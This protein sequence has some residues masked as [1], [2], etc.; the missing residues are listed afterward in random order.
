LLFIYKSLA[1]I[2]SIALSYFIFRY[3]EPIVRNIGKS[4]W[5][6]QYLGNGGTYTMWKIIGFILPIAVITYTILGWK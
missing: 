1:V 6:E 5:A 2:V 4:T 3:T